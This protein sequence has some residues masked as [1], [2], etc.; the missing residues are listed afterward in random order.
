[1]RQSEKI[2]VI[3]LSSL[4]DVLMALPAV[5]ALRDSH[6]GARISWLVEGSV[7]EFLSHQT[8]IDEVIP[9]PRSGLMRTLRRM[10]LAG[11]MGLSRRFI[12]HLRSQEYDSILDFHGIIKS[13]LLSVCVR[14]KGRK[15]GFGKTFAKEK[16]HLF[17]HERVDHWDRRIHKVDRNMLLSCKLGTTVAVPTVGLVAPGSAV[18]YIEDYL[19][20]SA[21]PMP[22]V[23][24]NPFSSQGSEFKRWDI[25]KYAGLAS[26]ISEEMGRSV[27]VLWGPGEESEAAELVRKAGKGV[28]LACPTTVSQ[29]FALLE[30]SEIYVGGDTGVMHLAVFAGVPVVAI[31][32]PTDP[33]INGPYGPS[34]TMIRRDLPCSPC[35]NKECKERRCL[36]EIAVEEV[37]ETMKTKYATIRSN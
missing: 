18:A 25:D 20:S 16:S 35:K 24:I 17:Y 21:I 34:H 27:V 11:T 10:D 29:L 37:Y 23:A 19:S 33:W 13:A 30:K 4:G 2:L 3:R 32:G 26:R 9:F 8:F 1:M 22:F 14:G 12:S 31:F 5:K 7:G 15:I 36:D 6:P 28:F